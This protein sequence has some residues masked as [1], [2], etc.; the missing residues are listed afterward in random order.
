[1]IRIHSKILL[2]PCNSLAEVTEV[3]C[4]QLFL[5]LHCAYESSSALR[6]S[7]FKNDKKEAE[8]GKSGKTKINRVCCTVDQFS[9]E[10]PLSF[11]AGKFKTANWRGRRG[12]KKAQSKP[13]ES[14]QIVNCNPNKVIFA[15]MDD[16]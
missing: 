9:G 16:I 13:V 2:T 1:M 3:G 4:A 12:Q 5:S 7:G 14:E 6:I 15:L 11:G 10:F 8:R